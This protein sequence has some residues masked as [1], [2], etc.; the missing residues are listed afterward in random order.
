MS[1]LPFSPSSSTL[2][3]LVVVVRTTLAVTTACTGA[4]LAAPSAH[5]Q[6]NADPA[7]I[8]DQ[9]RIRATGQ[10]SNI[11][12]SASQGSQAGGGGSAGYGP[13]S[14]R[15]SFNSS[16][17]AGLTRVRTGGVYIDSA[18]VRGSQIDANGTVSNARVSNATVDTG[19]VA[20]GKN[21]NN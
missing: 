9:T 5:A 7:T 20:I 2:G 14:L 12:A 4:L 15:G 19:V 13:F 18:A 6:A 17:S 1:C 21:A 11:D 8:V 10:A 16:S 3:R